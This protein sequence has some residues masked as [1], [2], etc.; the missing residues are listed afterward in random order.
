MDDTPEG[1]KL[2]ETIIHKFLDILEQNLYFLK[3]SKCEFLGFLVSN[4]QVCVELSKISG[5]SNWPLKLK[6]VKQVQQIPGVLGY[7]QSFIPNYTTKAK[8]L[9]NLLK[10]GIKF[11]WDDTCRKALQTLIRC[12]TKDPVLEAP[13]KGKPF[14]LKTN[15]STYKIGAILFQKDERGKRQAIGYASRSLNDTEW[16]Y[17]IWDREFLALIFG[18]TYWH[19]LLCGTKEPIQVYVDHTNLLHY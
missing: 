7:Q 8:P 6:N 14:E 12:I 17:D 1:R 5:I 19:H 11:I 16:N 3:I 4:G 2:H 9:T 10:K 15:A 13:Q 18:L